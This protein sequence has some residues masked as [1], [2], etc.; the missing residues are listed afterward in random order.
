[1]DI[2]IVCAIAGGLMGA[3]LYTKKFD[4]K[5]VIN[6]EKKDKFLLILFIINIFNKNF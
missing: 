4:K 6:L 5:M 3:F 1:M 2:I